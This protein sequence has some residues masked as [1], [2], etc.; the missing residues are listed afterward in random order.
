MKRRKKRAREWKEQEV[1]DIKD[2]IGRYKTIGIAKV[3]GIRAKQLQQIR[4]G[5]GERGTRLKVSK[6]SLISIAVRERDEEDM[7]PFIEDQMALIFTDLDSFSL[8]K[9]IEEGKIPAPLRAGAKAA[10]DIIIDKGAT[11]F[12]PGPIVGELQS[13]GISAGIEGGKVV[14][15]KRVVAVKEGERVSANMAEILARLEIYPLKEGLEL[16]AI[17]DNEEGVLFTPDVLHIDHSKYFAD[18]V[19]GAKAAFCIATCLKHTYPTRYTIGDSLIEAVNKAF[20]LSLNIGA[21]YPTSLTIR[22][23]IQMAHS[24][25]RN[26][27]I[28]ASICTY[29]RDTISY[30]LAKAYLCAQAL[31]GY[32]PGENV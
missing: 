4:R 30:F 17:Y 16:C 14:I 5:L 28:N 2:L 27:S 8:Y 1:S 29:K 13:L 9:T 15:K 20:C 25:A 3:R 7:I 12:R 6:N 24:Y 26:L 31:E 22:P 21:D 10:E 11:S 18:V 23:L 19:D 32:I